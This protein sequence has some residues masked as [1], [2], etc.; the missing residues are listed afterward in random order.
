MTTATQSRAEFLKA[1]E[2]SA[3]AGPDATLQARWGAA[4]GDTSQTSVLAG[5]RDAAAEASRQIA[6][7]A[8]ALALDT[9]TIE[10]VVF[11]LEGQ[12]VRV[13]YA[14]PAGGT[15]FGMS[16]ADI[17]MLVV[18]ATVDLAEG[19]TTIEGFVAL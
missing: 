3:V 16:S 12:T 13:S 4:G 9:V 15:Y 6:L 19:T 14:L 5:Q 7:L 10:G 1:E 8:P 17:D 11:D 18:R 2:R